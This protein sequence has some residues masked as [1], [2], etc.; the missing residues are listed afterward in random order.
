[1]LDIINPATETLISSVATDQPNSIAEKYRLAKI[2]QA[3][4]AQTPLQE[5]VA[6]LRKFGELIAAREGDLAKVLTAEV[7]KSITQSHNELKGLQARLSFFLSSVEATL[8]DEIVYPCDQNGLEERIVHEP[9]G[10]IANISA[11]NYPY[12]VSSNVF[13]PALLAGNAVLYKPSEYA[14]LSGL[15]M[16]QALHDAGISKHLFAAVIGPGEIGRE[17]ISAPVDGVF[18]TGSYGTGQKILS[19]LQGRLIK[20]QLEL[21]GKDPV[22]VCND[23]PVQAAA[24][25]IADG[26]MYNSGQSCCAV[27]RIYVHES[28]YEDFVKK[29]CSVVESFVIGDPLDDKT[30]IGPLT[31]KEQI[32]VLEDQIK[33]AVGKGAKILCGGKRLSDRKGYYFAPSVLV[34]VDHSMKLM[35]EESFGPIIGIQSVKNDEEALSRMNDTP[36]GLTAGVYTQDRDRASRLLRQLNVGSA[37]WN[38]CDR[39]SPRLPW[40]G[41][42]YS[43]IGLTLS[44]HGILAFTQPK[45]YHLKAS[46]S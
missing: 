25:S 8:R 31:R 41:R 22:Y 37:Y 24:E 43:G 19:A 39:V 17:L 5:R 26:A 11:W 2:A 13:I 21:G 45:A 10:V 14:T 46:K 9:L 40:S 28:I 27:E 44:I 36:Y 7:G 33:D 29:F 35:S 23:A 6:R 15:A 18:F 30:Y 38:A 34:D 32:A 42:G 3:D 20:V 16:T 1:M 12:F 4:W